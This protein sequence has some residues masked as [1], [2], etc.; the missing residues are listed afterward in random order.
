MRLLLSPDHVD[1]LTDELVE[2]APERLFHVVG[3]RI[4]RTTYIVTRLVLDDDAET[5]HSHCRASSRGQEAV[6]ALERAT[7]G[8]YLGI[9]HSHPADSP[10]PSHQDARAA[11]DLLDLNPTLEAALVGVV[12]A[13]P[14]EDGAGHR[15]DLGRGQLSAHVVERAGDGTTLL[16]MAV[17]AITDENAFLRS[18]HERVPA[19]ALA[20]L[21]GRSVTIF[22]AG[23]VGSTIA[24]QLTR[25]GV[26]ALHLID[27]D[28][29][30]PVNL[31]RS[32]FTTADLG[33]PKVEALADRLRAVNPLVEVTTSTARLDDDTIAPLSYAV[34]GA[35]LVVAATDDP[36][37]QG[38]ID[39][40][41]H[42]HDVA[43]LFAGVLPGAQLG[44]LV[45]VLPGVTTCYRCAVGQHRETAPATAAMDYGTGRQAGLSALG[46]DIA[47]LATVAARTALSLLELQH[48]TDRSLLPAIVSGRTV[49]HV[50]LSPAA[51]TGYGAFDTTPAQHQFQS[52]WMVPDPGEGCAACPAVPLAPAVGPPDPE[53]AAAGTG[54]DVP[55]ATKV[56]DEPS[57]QVMA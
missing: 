45:L 10:E 49:V 18:L 4:G 30:E 31:S 5:S 38:I 21:C 46:A 55:V 22:G 29:L 51:F 13:A 16:P 7:G 37:G 57:I 52:L 42:R 27:P 53:T 36:R 6:Q 8:Q 17:E 1:E 15:I 20:A 43:G 34:A 41:L 54:T 35:D 44:E 25:A 33:R 11:R 3:R 32:V 28:L 14:P 19:A 23:S 50:G 26:G 48:G 56:E 24:E 9:I 40:L 12:T 39:H 47:I 2:E